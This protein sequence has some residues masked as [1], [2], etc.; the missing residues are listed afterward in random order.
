MSILLPKL[1]PQLE[2]EARGV[3]LSE[4][5][6]DLTFF[7]VSVFCK[8]KNDALS[9]SRK[10]WELYALPGDMAVGGWGDDGS[11]GGGSLFLF[12]GKQNRYFQCRSC[13]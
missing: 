10:L 1:D 6:M 8:C 12:Y 9:N 2:A 7:R 13:F 5:G 11:G 3:T 4:V